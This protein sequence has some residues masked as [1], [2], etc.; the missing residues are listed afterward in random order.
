[1]LSNV[2]R[3]CH[4]SVCKLS[5]IN[6]RGLSIDSLTGFKVNNTLITSEYAF[7]IP[8]AEVVNIRF[9]S[10]DA[11][12]ESVSISINYKEFI[13]D[14]KVGYANNNADYAIFKLDFPELSGIPGLNLCLENNFEIGTSVA[15][16]GYASDCNNLSL[17]SA[18][19]S[20]FTKNSKGINYMVLD[21]V[22][23]IGNSGSPVIDPETMQVVAIVSKR[24]S[25]ATKEYKKIHDT[26]TANLSEL[27]KIEGNVKLGAID[28]IQMIIAN[29]NQIKL[30]ATNLYKHTANGTTQAILLDH[31]IGYFNEKAIVEHYFIEN[32]KEIQT[33]DTYSES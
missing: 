14:L 30:L 24:S 23:L 17:K 33:V 19:I 1:M 21:G 2:W 5:F 28:P 13:T 22:S 20:S 16:L 3:N 11:N 27:K 7:Y 26:I 10:Q 31:I 29:Q 32:T 12:S 25:A 4:A 6:E 18:T 8:K 15:M 9:V